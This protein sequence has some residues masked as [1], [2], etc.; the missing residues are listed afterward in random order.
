MPELVVEGTD[1][2]VRLDRFLAASPL[3]GT[4]GRAERLIEHGLVAV[5]GQARPKS[6]RL[7]RGSVVS[8]PDEEPAPDVPS[9]PVP[10]VPVL[11]ADDHVSAG[12]S[13]ATAPMRVRDSSPC[14]SFVASSARQR[15]TTRALPTW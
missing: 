2:G 9:E 1:A 6:H 10:G 14:A 5:D 8:F 15:R 13:V 4:R 11:Y 7:S 3:V 12:S